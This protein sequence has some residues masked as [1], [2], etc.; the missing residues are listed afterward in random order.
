[1]TRLKESC[2]LASTDAGVCAGYEKEEKSRGGRRFL[3]QGR[4]PIRRQKMQK[5]ARAFLRGFR[6]GRKVHQK[7]YREDR[8]CRQILEEQRRHQDRVVIWYRS[9]GGTG[10]EQSQQHVQKFVWGEKVVLVLV[11]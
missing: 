9:D 5:K 11:A 2:Y 8:R 10:V 7:A 3:K 1:M 6:G 4:I